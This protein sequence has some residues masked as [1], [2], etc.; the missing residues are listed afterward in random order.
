MI[1]GPGI[2]GSALI[3]DPLVIMTLITVGLLPVEQDR[4]FGAVRSQRREDVSI[5]DN[6][7]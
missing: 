5:G 2:N 6:G 7:R 4:I 1:I 3:D